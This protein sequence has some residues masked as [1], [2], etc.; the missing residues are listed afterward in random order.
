M[1]NPIFF[2]FSL[3]DFFQR[4]PTKMKGERKRNKEK[5]ILRLDI[6]AQRNQQ[7]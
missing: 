3:V 4:T 7:Y 5:N 6:Y 2:F 1:A